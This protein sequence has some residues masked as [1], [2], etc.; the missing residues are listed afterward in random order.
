LWEKVRLCRAVDDKGCAGQRLEHGADIAI[1]VE[2][3]R[4]GGAAAQR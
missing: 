1:G 2:I 3:M 4:P